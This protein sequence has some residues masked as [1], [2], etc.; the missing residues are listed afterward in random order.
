MPDYK[1]AS[2]I[3]RMMY[4][5]LEPSDLSTEALRPVAFAFFTNCWRLASHKSLLSWLWHSAAAS[6]FANDL[7]SFRIL[8][9]LEDVKPEH[10]RFKEWKTEQKKIWEE[11]CK[12]RKEDASNAMLDSA[13]RNVQVIVEDIE[14]LGPAIEAWFA[15]QV[16]GAWTTFETLAGDLWTEAINA[17][18][19]GLAELTGWSKRIVEKA[20]S[21]G[22]RRDLRDEGAF[23]GGLDVAESKR[24]DL[25]DIHRI[26]RGSYD[27]RNKIGDLLRPRFK[28]TTLAGI[29]KAYSVAFSEKEKKARP[30]A[31]DAALADQSLD[32]LAAVRNLIAHKAGVADDDYIKDAVRIPK[33]PR[34]ERGQQLQLDG[35]LCYSLIEPVMTRCFDLLTGVDK[36]LLLTGDSTNGTGSDTTTSGTGEAL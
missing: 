22:D 9:T 1:L 13:A 33:A 29:R 15:S 16:L 11:I 10:E 24:I 25:S 34:P 31:I 32:A 19:R 30:D 26:T 14:A 18:P 5:N 6:Q 4:K 2:F 35:D 36:W 8:G 27:I 23:G 12:L 20:G 17:R 3:Q 28:F 21:S 7:A